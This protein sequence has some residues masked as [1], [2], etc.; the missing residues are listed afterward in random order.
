MKG[1]LCLGLIVLLVLIALTSPDGS[2][3][4]VPIPREGQYVYQPDQRVRISPTT[5]RP[6]SAVT[7][8]AIINSK[9][10]G[11]HCTGSFIGPNVVLTA[12]HCLHEEGEWAHSVEV[13]PGRDGSTFGILPVKPYGSQFGQYFWVPNE[14]TALNPVDG[15]F[16]LAAAQFDYGI[17]V[18]P[19][20]SLGNQVGW[21]TM[22]ALSSASLTGNCSDLGGRVY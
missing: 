6:W 19:D 13:Q 7:Y 15:S 22:L 20:S 2:D 17:I 1:K 21:Q 8:L 3:A 9:G 11:G 5:Y 10:Q 16:S 12:A 14:W 4:Q 18:M